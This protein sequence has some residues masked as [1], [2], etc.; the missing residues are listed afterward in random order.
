[1]TLFTMTNK[2]PKILAITETKLLKFHI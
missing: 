1:M 2:L